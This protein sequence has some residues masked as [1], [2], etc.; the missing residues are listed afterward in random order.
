MAKNVT[1]YLPDDVAERMAKFAEV[2]WSEICR[3]AVIDYLDTRSHVDLASILEKLKNERNE[4][5]KQGKIL[6]YSKIASKLT[7]EIFQ[8]WYPRFSKKI[9]TSMNELG[10]EGL[11][12]E[13]AELAAVN[14]MRYWLRKFSKENNIDFPDDVS[15]AFCEGA[16]EAF[17]DIYKKARPKE[18]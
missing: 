8:I 14:E 9:L 5:Y 1:I 17:L 10:E 2:N 11:T 15:D 18:T 13:R 16:I 12:P 7:W 4:D 3:K 6:L